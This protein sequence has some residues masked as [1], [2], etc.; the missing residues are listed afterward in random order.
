MTLI[1]SAR[2][3][4]DAKSS[5][6]KTDTKQLQLSVGV[7]GTENASE[8][9][10]LFVQNDDDTD[11]K[12]S[13]IRALMNDNEETMSKLTEVVFDDCDD[14]KD[15][16]YNEKGNHCDNDNDDQCYSKSSLIPS[17]GSTTSFIASLTSSTCA[18][19]PYLSIVLE[20]YNSFTC[21]ESELTHL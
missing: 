11:S 19:M 13:A 7:A 18:L 15:H 21:F 6:D 4:D 10:T 8:T 20:F 17:S 14:E 5:D 12:K 3:A 9:V 16:G 2:N 1:A